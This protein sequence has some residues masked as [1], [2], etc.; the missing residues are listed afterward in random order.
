M[1]NWKTTIAG[2]AALL[3]IISK[4]VTSGHLEFSTDVPAAIAAVGLLFAKDHN[5]TGGTSPQ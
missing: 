1:R 2:V 4:A 5:V 3:A